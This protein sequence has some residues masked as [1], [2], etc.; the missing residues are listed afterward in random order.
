MDHVAQFAQYANRFVGRVTNSG[1]HLRAAPVLPAVGQGV[2]RCLAIS[3]GHIYAE[4]IDQH[5]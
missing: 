4:L 3:A 5:R 2:E 1:P